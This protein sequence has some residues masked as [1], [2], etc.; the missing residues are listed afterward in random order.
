MAAAA[1][2]SSRPLA[3]AG[4]SGYVGGRLVRRLLQRGHAVRCLVRDARKLADRRFDSGVP[5]PTVVECDGSDQAALTAALR[6]VEVAYYL[7]HSMATAGPD[8]A[9][10]DHTLAHTFGAAA[11][12]A[13]VRRIVYLGGLG[14]L[15]PGL[16]AH[17]RSRREVETCLAA[18]GVPVTTF[19]AAMLVGS[20]SASFEIL[21]YLAERLPIMVTPRWVATESQPIAIEN[22]LHYLVACLDEPRTIGRS[23]DIGGPDVLSYRTLLQQT[24]QALGLGRRWILPVPVLTPALSSFWVHLVTPVSHRIARPLA[25]GLRNR[26]VAREHDAAALMPQR[27][28]PMAEAIARA[29]QDR[30]ET[31]WHDAGVVPGDPDWAGGKVFVDARSMPIAAP[32][33]AVFAVVQGLGGDRGWLAGDWLWRLRGALDKLVGGPGSR[34]GR[35]DPDTLRY[36]D[37]LDFWRVLEVD[38]PRRLRLVAEM[39][40]PGTATLEFEVHD[41]GADACELVQT[42]RFR[43]RGLFGLGYWYSVLPLHAYV[44][45]GMLRGIRRRA[46]L[47]RSPAAP[48][49]G[50][51]P[52]ATTRSG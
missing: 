4:A 51:T 11:A 42:A 20:G 33:A 46:E 24:A 52:A 41:R 44:F 50:G 23:F 1:P 2:G 3:V 40:L 8:F 25:E 31:A 21:R 48:A 14:E 43:P 29:L 22:V 17:L 6:G 47:S 28:L 32:A 30:P 10:R 35:R 5:T 12:A 49:G 27:L 37:A 15:G 36:G 34:R 45:A 13:G 39:R 38:P 7:I 19:R 16:S 18:A 9:A 26:M